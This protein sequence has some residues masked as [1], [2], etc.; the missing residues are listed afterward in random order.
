MKLGPLSLICKRMIKDYRFTRS[1]FPDLLLWNTYAKSIKAVEV[2]GPGDQLS[3]KQTLWINY[4]S[5]IGI[6]SE[7]CRVQPKLGSV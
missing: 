5:S 4:L 2:K 3:T 6:D 7:V 1:G